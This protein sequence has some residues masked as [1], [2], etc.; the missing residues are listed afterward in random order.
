MLDVMMMLVASAED[1]AALRAAQALERAHDA[2]LS[3]LV[4]DKPIPAE[5]LAGVVQS[6]IW[7]LSAPVDAPPRKADEAARLMWGFSRF[8][9]RPSIRAVAVVDGAAADH[10]GIAAR[11]ANLTLMLR[12]WGAGEETLRRSMFESALYESGRPVLLVPPRWRG[13]VLGAVVLV[14]WD[15]SREATRAVADAAFLFD[16]AERVVFLTVE[17]GARPGPSAQDMAVMVR[18]R[19]VQ[20]HV[21]SAR[22]PGESVDQVL[23]REAEAIGA[24]LIVMGAYG[25][26]RM[27]EMIFGGVTRAM[28]R[29]SRIPL[30]LSR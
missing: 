29:S 25:H 4:F 17:T 1:E 5:S 21:R 16:K 28:V 7:T 20:C 27:H 26:A 9:R 11:C 22:D 13:P 18:R 24:D 19:G 3:A 30:F 6:G 12:P 23:M 2:A 15:G 14:A 10:P 8:A